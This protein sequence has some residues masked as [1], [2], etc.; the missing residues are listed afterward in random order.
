M[1]KHFEAA[2][3]HTVIEAEDDA[4]MD[5]EKNDTIHKRALS[6]DSQNVFVEL[7]VPLRFPSSKGRNKS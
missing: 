5:E 7:R 4:E 3:A 2:G 1:L 6:T